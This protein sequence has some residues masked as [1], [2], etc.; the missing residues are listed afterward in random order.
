RSSLA[1][2]LAI[3][4]YNAAGTVAQSVPVAP[5][6]G[7]SWDTVAFGRRSLVSTSDMKWDQLSTVVSAN[8]NDAT[9]R[10]MSQL[11]T[12]NQNDLACSQMTV[13]SPHTELSSCPLPYGVYYG[14]K[15]G[16]AYIIGFYSHSAVDGGT[17]LCK[18][19]REMS[20]FTLLSR[21][22]GYIRSVLNRSFDIG[23]STFG[24]NIADFSPTYSMVA[25]T[26]NGT[27]SVSTVSG[28]T[29][30]GNRADNGSSAGSLDTA[31]GSDGMSPMDS[32]LIGTVE[33][34][35]APYSS[36]GLSQR[37]TII[38]AVCVPVLGLLMIGAV[39]YFVCRRPKP[40]P[41]PLDPVGQAQMHELFQT[42][43]GCATHAQQVHPSAYALHNAEMGYD[44][45]PVYDDHPDAIS[46]RSASSDEHFYKKKPQN[47]KDGDSIKD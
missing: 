18:Y 31:D 24:A 27:I 20:Y 25:D 26:V 6:L 10:E 21:Y 39:L 47:E 11:Y 23:G 9:C 17:D 16:R 35:Q 34:G 29:Y 43:L 14:I 38:V 5:T 30:K 41:R 8:P 1:N 32:G 15:G 44:L 12:Q 45:P 2:N 37:N 33:D 46:M 28:N 36:G 13:R 4:Q 3:L 40:G 19:S 7:Y 22:I 42:E